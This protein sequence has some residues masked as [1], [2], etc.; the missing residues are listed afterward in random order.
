MMYFLLQNRGKRVIRN[1]V[2]A[3]SAVA[4]IVILINFVSPEIVNSML[5]RVGQSTRSSQ[6]DQFFSQIRLG[7]L[8]RGLGYNASYVFLHWKN[9]QFI[10]NQIIFSAF[11][12]G[13][14]IIGIQTYFL[15]KPFFMSIPLGQEVRTRSVG[16]IHFVLAMM[17][18]SIY[19]S[20]SIDIYCVIAYALAGRAYMNAKKTKYD[21]KTILHE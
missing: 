1:I 6:L 18:I 20:L 19:F 9:Y 11:R 4:V 7:S 14:T 2:K 21:L 15:L 13:I 5:A 12:Y 17:G 10:D 16:V 3:V 8:V